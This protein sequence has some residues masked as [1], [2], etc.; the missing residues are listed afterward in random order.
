[1][2]RYLIAAAV[3]SAA[4][5]A[6]GKYDLR[7]SPDRQIQHVLNR[8]TFGPRPGDVAEVRRMGVEKWVELQ[9]H[10]DRIP[11]N[12]VV[13]QRLKPLE[14][15]R[16]E[17]AQAIQQYQNLRPA[18][19]AVRAV[20]LNDVLKPDQVSMLFNG[21]MAERGAVLKS[22]DE[23]KRMAILPLIPP[24]VLEGFPEYQ[25]EL[26]T[27]RKK[28]QEMLQ[29]EARKMRPPLTDI[30]SSQQL[31]IAQRGTPQQKAELFASLDE[32]KRMQVAAGLPPQALA[33]QPELR[34][35][36]MLTRQPLQVPLNDLR[37]AKLFRA[38][39]SNRQLEEVLTDFWFNHFNVFEG[40]GQDRVLLASYERDA[41][42]PYVLGK[43]RDLL[44][45]TAR[46][47]A[48]L[49]Y[50]DNWE[51][52]AT[53]VFQ[54][55]PF[56]PGPFANAQALA[57]QA[58]GLNENYGR[59]LMELHTLGVDGGY[60]QADVVAVAKCFTGWTIRQPNQKPE[61]A[62][63]AFMHDNGEK[64][65]LG[66]KIAANGG[67]HDGMQV[68]DIL[69]THPSTARFI[70]KKLAR[71]FV[72]DDPPAALVD[73][74]AKTFLKTGGDLRAVLQTMF[75]SREFLSEGAW[76]SKMKSPFE[77]VVSAIRAVGATTTDTFTVA[78]R[79]EQMGEP[80][81]GK[82]EPTGYRETADAWLSTSSVL[83][84]INFANQL[85]AGSMPGVKVDH[86]RFDGKDWNSIAHELLN[87][88]PS[89]QTRT[90]IE[91]GLEGQQPNPGVIAGLVISSPEFQRR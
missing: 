39:Y 65:V 28:R 80:L 37:E 40:K 15:T 59:E 74:M 90:A 50:L 54:L 76:Q 69:A 22:L 81:Y 62:F 23:E 18:A 26:E 35:L 38:I 78:Q 73:R 2:K 86:G 4:I 53:D 36:G 27:A 51:S 66:R 91:K 33:D 16:M 20:S 17:M 12:P 49:I 45:A 8:L 1:M 46:H 7:L 70:S 41:I 79:I 77:M 60:T 72:A 84:R 19:A 9:L 55:G 61:F 71:R 11:E 13:E 10:P 68:I 29:L 63:A 58:R 75:A 30:L 85:T 82:L 67:E 21:L 87:R 32:T 56:A 47:P 44:L 5:L 48:M 52:M 64:T 24:R 88:D 57:R 3:A 14:F 6:S 25:M 83:A 43:F 34:R 31:M 89:E 42:R